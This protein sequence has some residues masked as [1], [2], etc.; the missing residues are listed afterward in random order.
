[1]ATFDVALFGEMMVLLVAADPGPLEQVYAFHKM[2][3]GA[4]TNVGIALAR[5]GAKVA[6]ASRL[7]DDTMGRYLKNV[8]QQEAIDCSRVLMVPR[9]RTGFMLKGKVIEGD[10][11]I[12]YYRSGSAASAMTA[13]DLDPDWLG[14][15]RHLHVTGIFPALNAGTYALTIAAM[16]HM[17]RAGGTV[18][19]DPNLRPALWGSTEVMRAR[20][21][22][23]AGLADW[24]LPGLEEGRILT[25]ADNEE[26]IAAFYQGL[27]AQAVVVKLGACG[28]FGQAGG[29]QFRVP[30]YPVETVVDTVGAGDG[31]AAGLISGR[32][33][34]LDWQAS[35]RR[36]TIIGACAVQVAGDTEGYPDRARLAQLDGG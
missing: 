14:Q 11:P 24:V 32:L 3:A 10:P 8:M 18:S 6:W 5:L 16:Q 31:F 15:A 26:G 19:F 22:E 35:V 29:H 17:R 20:L 33:E 23:L 4:E 25:G 13:E 12:E 1:M 9:E 2:T 34:G 28:A 7:G 21:N 36:A 27:G 30:G